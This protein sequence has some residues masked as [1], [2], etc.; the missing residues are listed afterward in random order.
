MS[1]MD[2]ALT[3]FQVTGALLIVSGVCALR[4]A[5]YPVKGVGGSGPLPPRCPLS[6]LTGGV[7]LFATG[8]ASTTLRGLMAVVPGW[9]WV[10][11]IGVT[12]GAAISLP[13][14]LCLIQVRISRARTRAIAEATPSGPRTAGHSRSTATKGLDS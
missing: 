7:L 10:A 8:L 6:I 2:L 12:L 1:A 14:S 13:V 5:G 3:M 4:N 11:A 9:V